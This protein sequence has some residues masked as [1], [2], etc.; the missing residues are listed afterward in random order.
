MAEVG[1]KLM[2]LGREETFLRHRL[3]VAVQAVDHDHF[4]PRL[5]VFPLDGPADLV[6]KLPRRKLGRV[7]G[8]DGDVARVEVSGKVHPEAGRPLENG[9][10]SLVEGEDGSPLAALSRSAGVL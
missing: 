3:Q 1:K 8:L 9:L 2:E 5:T 6:G 4:C 7:D 10:D